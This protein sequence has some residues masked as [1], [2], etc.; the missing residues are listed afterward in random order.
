VDRPAARSPLEEKR[1]L[2]IWVELTG[3]PV[4]DPAE[5]SKCL[6]GLAIDITAR[7]L[8]EEALRE[9]ERKMFTLLGNLPGI[10]Y[11]CRNDRDWTMEF[12]SEGAGN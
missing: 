11:R 9:S 12:I 5:K 1:R 3:H 7:K 8:A 2:S 6:E 4:E 10:A